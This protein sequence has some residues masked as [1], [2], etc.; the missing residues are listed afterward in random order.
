MN[1]GFIYVKALLPRA[2]TFST[3]LQP[4]EKNKKNILSRS[5][6]A[7]SRS[8]RLQGVKALNSLLI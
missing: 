5:T 8:C 4:N 1:N 7:N 3:Q 2:E 6:S